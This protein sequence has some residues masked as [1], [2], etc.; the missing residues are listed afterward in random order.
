MIRQA[1]VSLRVWLTLNWDCDSRVKRSRRPMSGPIGAMQESSSGSANTMAKVSLVVLSSLFLFGLVATRLAYLDSPPFGGDERYVVL[2]ALKFGTGD[3]NPRFFDWPAS[4]LF[5]LNFLIYGLL[6]V[7]GRLTGAYAGAE[8]FVLEYLASPRIFYLVP[9]LI[10]AGFGLACAPVVARTGGLLSGRHAGLAAAILLLA[11][12]IHCAMSRWGLAD[13]PMTFF[14]CAT[15]YFAARIVKEEE[16]GIRLYLLAGGMVGLAAAMKYHGALAGLF[17]AS[18]QV[19]RDFR[20]PRLRSV[21]RSLADPKLVTAGATSLLVF[22]MVTPFAV[23]DFGTFRADLAFQFNHQRVLGHAGTTT[24][25]PAVTFFS[26]VPGAIGYPTFALAWA[27]LGIG[28]IRLRRYGA[29]LCLSLPVI[30][31]GFGLFTLSKVQ[32]AYY[33]LP[34]LPCLCLLAGSAIEAA[35]ELAARSEKT[36]LTMVVASALGLA[37]PSLWREARSALAQGVPETGGAV[38]AWVHEHCPPDTRIA[39]DDD[40]L[41]LIP[42][43]AA[44]QRNLELAR[45]RGLT[46]RADYW[47]SLDRMIAWDR[48]NPHYDLDILYAADEAEGCLDYLQSRNVEYFIHSKSIEGR[49]ESASTSSRRQSRLGF[50]EDLKSRAQVVAVFDS[51]DGRYR[52]SPFAIYQFP[53]SVTSTV[54]NRKTGS[55]P[56]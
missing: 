39:L 13:V 38:V 20:R 42:S 32:F 35:G 10:S 22:L 3:L 19:Y 34:V 41:N 54:T 26:K 49:F 9:R 27:G 29:L 48:K 4:P 43:R 18:A 7:G 53:N 55:A 23:L 11:A 45:K 51:K 17:V 24:G 12:P 46:G 50:Y 30:V 28:L 47:S 16:P 5:Y 36:R 6:Y 40:N 1:Q 2:H 33:L 37:S 44:V 31:T 25:P 15:L 8:S 14:V 56:Q 52:G 21:A